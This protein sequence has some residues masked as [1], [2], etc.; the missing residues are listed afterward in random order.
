MKKIWLILLICIVIVTGNLNSFG[1]NKY[2]KLDAD[3][4]NLYVQLMEDVYRDYLKDSGK[5]EFRVEWLDIPHSTYIKGQYLDRLKIGYNTAVKVFNNKMKRNKL[6]VRFIDTGSYDDSKKAL[7]EKQKRRLDGVVH[8][9]IKKKMPPDASIYCSARP[10]SL[11]E[12]CRAI[13]LKCWLLNDNKGHELSLELKGAILLPGKK[14]ENPSISALY[15]CPDC[16][17]VRKIKDGSVVH[18]NGKIWFDVK[19]PKLNGFLIVYQVD[20]KG[21]IFNLFPGTADALKD[22]RYKIMHD[23]YYRP[24]T[25]ILKV[26]AINSEKLIKDDIIRIGSFQFDDTV[27]E[28]QYFFYYSKKRN[29]EIER[30][31]MEAT[32]LGKPHSETRGSISGATPETLIEK[33]DKK[34]EEE[35]N[36][37]MIKINK[38]VSF[39]LL[40][41]HEEK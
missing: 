3:I 23:L 39:R 26:A 12:G 34:E 11:R 9:P 2:E 20:S 24:P 29:L 1:N 25:N 33:I 13:W 31:L 14:S 21:K 30:F 17:D 8:V 19:L 32:P 28:E 41:K 16:I 36:R 27:G 18:S 40:H 35:K 38:I 15:R 10:L 4:L 7:K 37:E 22:G 6:L 5:N